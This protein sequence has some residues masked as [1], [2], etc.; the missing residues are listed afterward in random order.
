MTWCFIYILTFAFTSL[1][2]PHQNITNWNE[3][4]RNLSHKII[5]INRYDSTNL[6]RLTRKKLFGYESLK[7]T[8]MNTMYTPCTLT[9]FRVLLKRFIIL[10]SPET[11][12]KDLLASISSIAGSDLAWY[13]AEFNWHLSSK[14][15]TA[16]NISLN[17]AR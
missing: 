6:I 5:S 13:I 15:I 17:P 7:Y 12:I 14:Q 9:T 3:S 8:K 16:F 2:F 11:S 1:N 10:C 4:I